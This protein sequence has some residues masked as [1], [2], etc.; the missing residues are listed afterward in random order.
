MTR[1]FAD[2]AQPYVDQTRPYAGQ[3]QSKKVRLEPVQVWRGSHLQ[4][5][6]NLMKGQTEHPADHDHLPPF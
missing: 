2:Q 1:P 4:I 6:I 3:A 5:R